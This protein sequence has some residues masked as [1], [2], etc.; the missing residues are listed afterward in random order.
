MRNLA[1]EWATVHPR[2][3]AEAVRAF[4]LLRVGLQAA[5]GAEEQ[6]VHRPWGGDRFEPLVLAIGTM[7]A[8]RGLCI[9]GNCRKDSDQPVVP[10]SRK[11]VSRS[12]TGARIGSFRRWKAMI[13]T[14][15]ISSIGRET[16]PRIP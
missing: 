16:K 8:L 10:A 15:G 4:L 6:Q 3:A 11:A 14:S 13:E 1:I 7:N 12:C 2:S 9:E 5:R